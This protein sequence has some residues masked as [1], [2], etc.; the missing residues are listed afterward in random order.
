MVTAAI[1]QPLSIQ[2][3][4]VLRQV[5]LAFLGAA[6]LTLCSKIAIPLG[7]TPVPL[8]LQTFAIL[9]LAS[10]CPASM[11]WQSLA[12]YLAAG[13]TGLPVFASSVA[14]LP[15]FMGPTGGYIVGFIAATAYLLHR[16]SAAKA[17]PKI[18]HMLIASALILGLG[19]VGLS[20]YVGVK[21]A[22]V[23][24]VLPFLGGDI[25]KVL[26][27]SGSVSWLKKA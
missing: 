7:F 12:V 20:F 6:F 18:I 3:Q 16:P 14:G 5:S 1:L 8:T 9:L 22:I 23:L 15:V 26:V 4:G 24:G 17:A 25:L 2:S 21:Q 11:A 27:L 10:C 19:S 13:A